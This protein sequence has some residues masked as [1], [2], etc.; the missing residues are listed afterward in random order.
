MLSLQRPRLLSS[1]FG[2]RRAR[3]MGE[4]VDV[5]AVVVAAALAG[6][7]LAIAAFVHPV[8]SRLDDVTHTRAVQPLARVTGRAMPFWYAAAVLLAGAAVWARPTGDA[9]W[10]LALAAAGLLAGSIAFTLLGPLP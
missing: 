3:R 5:A 1:V 9:G 10:W 6:N 4:A 7:E 2:R 8:L